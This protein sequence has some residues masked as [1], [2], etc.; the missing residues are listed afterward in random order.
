MPVTPQHE[1]E[2]RQEGI[3]NI[4]LPPF[5]TLHETTSCLAYLLILLLFITFKA[6][7]GS[8]YYILMLITTLDS[9]VF[10]RKA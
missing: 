6:Y 9:F 10:M 2:W 8:V 4:R 7:G 5:L 3:E 1:G